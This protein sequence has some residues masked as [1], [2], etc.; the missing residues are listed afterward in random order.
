MSDRVPPL[1]GGRL[2]SRAPAAPLPPPSDYE[3][4][5]YFRPPCLAWAAGAAQACSF[6]PCPLKS[7]RSRK[8]PVRPLLC[9]YLCRPAGGLHGDGFRRLPRRFTAQLS[10]SYPCPSAPSIRC[11][12]YN[13]PARIRLF[14]F[15]AVCQH[16]FLEVYDNSCYNETVSVYLSTS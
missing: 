13:Q 12:R 9:P 10:V 14:A 6:K 4:G 1:R 7:R 15:F 5:R 11:S 3:A 8:A 2:S 16:I